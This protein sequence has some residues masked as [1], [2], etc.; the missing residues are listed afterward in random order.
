MKI[1]DWLT[2]ITFILSVRFHEI[3]NPNVCLHL[4]DQKYISLNID[5]SKLHLV[6][7]ESNIGKPFSM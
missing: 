3:I 7:S 5:E 1:F 2:K 4:L 6:E